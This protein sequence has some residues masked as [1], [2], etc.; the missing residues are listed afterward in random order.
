MFFFSSDN[1]IS[2]N[3]YRIDLKI[4]TRKNNNLTLQFSMR[5]YRKN[6]KKKKKYQIVHVQLDFLFRAKFFLLRAKNIDPTRKRQMTGPLKEKKKTFSRNNKKKTQKKL[7]RC[8]YEL[9]PILYGHV[10][11]KRSSI[12][13][14]HVTFKSSSILK[15]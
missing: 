4:C 7:Y 12:L 2:A 11:F 15:D 5:K 8:I 9:S 13:Y 14:G 3:F 1:K 6:L 10:T